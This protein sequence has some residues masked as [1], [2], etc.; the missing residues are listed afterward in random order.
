LEYIPVKTQK[1]N[2]SPIRVPLTPTAREI[3]GRYKEQAET[4]W[5]LLPFVDEK[6]YNEAIREVFVRCGITRIVTRLNPST[7]KEEQRPINELASSHMARKCFV[8]ALYKKVRDPSLIGAL[9]GH[10]EGSTAFARYREIDEE[11][12][13]ETV[14]LIE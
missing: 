2:P 14:N 8:G 13:I 4:S 1:R 9:S 5:R 11:I 12:K 3:V 10:A 7:G 6:R